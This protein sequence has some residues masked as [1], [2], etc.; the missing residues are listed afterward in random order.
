M[1]IFS[2]CQRRFE[3][4]QGELNDAIFAADFGDL[5]AGR[6]ADVCADSAE[7]AWWF[8]LMRNDRL[9][10]GRRALRILLEAAK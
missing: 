6:S 3:V 2:S 8:G 5:S 10:R 9:R 7:A 4:R 1:S